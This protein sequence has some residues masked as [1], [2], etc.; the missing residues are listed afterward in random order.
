M[1]VLKP[2]IPFMLFVAFKL[3]PYK[4]YYGAPYFQNFAS[5]PSVAEGLPQVLR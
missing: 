3:K 5:L 1:L 4:S 2:V